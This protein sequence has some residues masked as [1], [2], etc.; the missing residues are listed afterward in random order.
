MPP[1]PQ[2]VRCLLTYELL[3]CLLQQATH[4]RERRTSPAHASCETWDRTPRKPYHAYSASV[5]DPAC[6]R[7]VQVSGGSYA[8]REDF[9]LPSTIDARMVV[10]E[11]WGSALLIFVGRGQDRRAAQTPRTFTTVLT[12]VRETAAAHRISEGKHTLAGPP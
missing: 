5:S 7:T 2:V 8:R 10:R 3:S 9:G 11:K 1:F 12:P 4:R 6:R